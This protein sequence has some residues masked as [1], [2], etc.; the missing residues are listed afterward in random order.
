[1][2]NSKRKPKRKNQL[3]GEP[4]EVYEE[5]NILMGFG[6]FIAAVVIAVV[7]GFLPGNDPIV[8]GVGGLLIGIGLTA[9]AMQILPKQMFIGYE[10]G[11]HYG[12]PNDLN[13]YRWEDFGAVTLKII[14]NVSDAVGD[15]YVFDFMDMHNN[16]L[17]TVDSTN[18]PGIQ[19]GA[20]NHALRDASENGILEYTVET[21]STE[22]K[23]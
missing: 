12:K 13:G 7:I 1:M 9:V 18:C 3:L 5:R 17:I 21:H 19:D 4:I 6:L 22:K 23:G 11:V 8:F 15:V 2:R 20:L 14:K 16:K 10:K